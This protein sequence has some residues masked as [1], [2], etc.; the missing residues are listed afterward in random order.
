MLGQPP[1]KYGIC[2]D[3][4]L[5]PVVVAAVTVVLAGVRNTTLGSEKDGCIVAGRYIFSFYRGIATFL[6]DTLRECCPGQVCQQLSPFCCLSLASK[7]DASF[8][9]FESFLCR[10]ILIQ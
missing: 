7:C 3:Q 6:L 1:A 2:R 8:E 9:S 4:R 5:N 10:E